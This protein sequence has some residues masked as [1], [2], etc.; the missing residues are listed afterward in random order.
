M[1]KRPPGIFR[2]RLFFI[3]EDR[4]ENGIR[5]LS[6]RRKQ[7]KMHRMAAVRLPLIQH[8]LQL[9]SEENPKV[10]LIDGFRILRIEFRLKK[11]CGFSAFSENKVYFIR[12]APDRNPEVSF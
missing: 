4:L 8:K 11:V 1:H 3:A 7:L 2:G 10:R 9:F 5:K 6:V 12:S